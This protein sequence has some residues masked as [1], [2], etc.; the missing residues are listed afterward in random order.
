MVIPPRLVGLC[1]NI[2]AKNNV[3][4]AKGLYQVPNARRFDTVPFVLRIKLL[5]VQVCNG[6][7]GKDLLLFFA[8]S[9][10]YY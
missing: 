3:Y 7:P 2:R 5:P 9:W 8:A 10:K 1:I 6:S 4:K